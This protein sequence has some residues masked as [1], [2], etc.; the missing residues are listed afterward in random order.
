MIYCTITVKKNAYLAVTR[1]V[2]GKRVMKKKKHLFIHIILLLTVPLVACGNKDGETADTASN[3]ADTTNGETVSSDSTVEDEPEYELA[4][5]F[6]N[7]NN[8]YYEYVGE[9][10]EYAGFTEYTEYAE[11]NRKQFRRNNTG[12]VVAEVVELQENQ[13]I[14]LYHEGE[15]YHRG[16][17][18]DAS[19]EEVEVLI[20]APLEEGHSWEIPFDRT[21]TITGLNVPVSTLHGE[22]ETLEITIEWDNEEATQIDYY[23]PGIGLVKSIYKDADGLEVLT[24]LKSIT[25]QPLEHTIRFYYPDFEREEVVYTD[26]EIAMNT[27]DKTREA[28]ESAYKEVPGELVPVLSENV[29]INYLYLNEDGNVYVDFSRELIDEMNAGSGLESM[30]LT[31]LVN[32]IGG[33][34]NVESVYLTVDG[35]PY[36]SGHIWIEEGEFIP[37]TIDQAPAYE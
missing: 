15:T 30:I 23:A 2:R 27:N 36:Q 5:F 33:Y 28:I 21:R 29:E 13:I 9:G 16:N 10:I 4:D 31:S 6:P 12:T 35:A 8:Q 19:D 18:L 20:Q 3:Q 14:V 25:E 11:G 37:V 24:D 22:Y 26:K 1:E 7:T 32:T 34:Y 17:V